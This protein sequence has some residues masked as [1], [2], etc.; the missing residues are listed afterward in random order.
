MGVYFTD[1]YNLDDFEIGLLF[2]V[3]TA[4]YLILTPFA[5]KY[6]KR[7][8]SYESLLFMGT[9]IMGVSFLFLGPDPILGIKKDIYVVSVAFVFIGFGC[10]LVYIPALP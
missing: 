2:T 9:L 10:I 4:V 7:F 8:P 1:E 5:A 6:I 3:S